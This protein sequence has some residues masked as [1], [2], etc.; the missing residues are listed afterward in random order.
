LVVIPSEHTG[1]AVAAENS[2]E[3]NGGRGF[4]GSAFTVDDG[5]GAGPG[6]VLADGLNISPFRTFGGVGSK[7]NSKVANDAAPAAGCWSFSRWLGEE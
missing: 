4:T 1:T 6:P 2:R 5:D 7:A 3:Q